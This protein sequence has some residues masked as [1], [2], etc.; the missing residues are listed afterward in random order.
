MVSG[1]L[2]GIGAPISQPLA[3]QGPIPVNNDRG[4]APAFLDDLQRTQPGAHHAA[5]DLT[6]EDACRKA[7]SETADIGPIRG[8]VNNAGPTMAS[9]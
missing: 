4:S 5:A 9:G 2:A 6:D 7:V 8:L 3:A 1:S